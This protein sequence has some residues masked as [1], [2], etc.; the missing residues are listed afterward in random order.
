MRPVRLLLRPWAAFISLK[1]ADYQSIASRMC[2]ARRAPCVRAERLKPFGYQRWQ[3]EPEHLVHGRHCCSRYRSKQHAGKAH[4]PSMATQR[5][6]PFTRQTI[7]HLF[8][9]RELAPSALSAC[10]LPPL[11]ALLFEVDDVCF[12]PKGRRSRGTL[13]ILEADVLNRVFDIRKPLGNRGRVCS[14]KTDRL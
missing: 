7:P 3:V 9:R 11:A 8:I 14:V 2:E 6:N 1:S 13:P 12:R 4:A 5:S 10:F